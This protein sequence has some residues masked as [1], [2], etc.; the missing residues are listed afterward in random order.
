MSNKIDKINFIKILNFWTSLVIQWL[1]LYSSNAEGMG[2][3]SC[4]GTRV[5]H[6]SQ[7]TKI[8]TFVHQ[9]TLLRKVKIQPI[10][11]KK[12]LK[13]LHLIWILY[14]WLSQLNNKMTTQ[15]KKWSKDL[16][17]HFSGKDIQMYW[18]HMKSGTTS[19]VVR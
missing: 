2:L 10:K 12:Y 11:W 9:R 19:L 13:L 17:R 16:N 6:V 3:I 4:Q 7:P 5:P 18:K 1:R 8:K 14:K 15:F